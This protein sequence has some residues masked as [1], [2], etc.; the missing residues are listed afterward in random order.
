MTSLVDGL[1]ERKKKNEKYFQNYRD[2]ALKI[3]EIVGKQPLRD[4]RVLVFGSVVKGTWIP[5][6]SDIDI[7][8]I[9]DD[10]K[11]SASWQN[12]LK[13]K[14]LRQIADLS[15][16]FELHFA[17]PVVYKEWYEGFIKGDFI[18]V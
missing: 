13:L 11:M 9:S 12:D 8:I 15:S 18:E 7:L 3:K 17:T 1:I 2:Y 14:I 16:P 6:R 10:V 5:N 4:P